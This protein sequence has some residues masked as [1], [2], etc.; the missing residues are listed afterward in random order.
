[1]TMIGDDTLAVWFEGAVPYGLVH[2]GRYYE[3]TDEPTRLEEEMLGITHPPLITG[4]RF[5]ATDQDRVSHM[6][7]IAKRD[8]GWAVVRVY[9]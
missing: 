3:V 1:M 5:Q 9:D 4:W 6:F 2:L 7:V 8:D